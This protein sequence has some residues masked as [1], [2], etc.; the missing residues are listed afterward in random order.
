MASRRNQPKAPKMSTTLTDTILP[1][2]NPDWG[3]WGTMACSGV[4]TPGSGPGQAGAAEAWA[5]AFRRIAEA[6]GAAPEGV[7]DFLDSRHG[8][9][10]ADE[11]GNELWRGQTLAA[12]IE[13]A[14]ARWMGWRIDRHTARETGIPAGL[15]YLTGWVTHFAILDEMAA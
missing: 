2:R 7:R 15:P 5:I 1:T 6:T 12:A 8:R 3:Y 11:V 9:H 4:A 10:F 14:I 13:A